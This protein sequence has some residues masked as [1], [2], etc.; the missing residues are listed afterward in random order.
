MTK[1]KLILYLAL[2][3]FILFGWWI[4]QGADKDVTA[5]VQ[6]SVNIK[7]GK[8]APVFY[9]FYKW[10]DVREKR[11]TWLIFP[12]DGNGGLLTLGSY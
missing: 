10:N 1:K 3:V 4:Y 12:R 5:R 8:Q 6:W 9:V 2:S 7:T 11:P